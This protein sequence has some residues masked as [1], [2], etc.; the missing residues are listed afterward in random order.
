MLLYVLFVL[1][2]SLSS[3]ER[4]E[5]QDKEP[6]G[7]QAYVE[8]F[9]LYCGK[10]SIRSTWNIYVS[11]LWRNMATRIPTHTQAQPETR[12]VLRLHGSTGLPSPA[13]LSVNFIQL[14]CYL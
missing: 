14:L 3:R 7:F 10:L 12:N 11:H 13:I 6:R 2:E 1:P 4:E 5:L 9:K 8:G